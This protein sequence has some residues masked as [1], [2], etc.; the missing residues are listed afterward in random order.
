MSFDSEKNFSFLI[1]ATSEY[2]KQYFLE[3]DKKFELDVLDDEHKSGKNGQ[4]IR[5]FKEDVLKNLVIKYK[6]DSTLIQRLFEL[7]EN[8][9]LEIKSRNVD[10]I[11][12][13]DTLKY[14]KTETEPFNDQFNVSYILACLNHNFINILEVKESIFSKLLANDLN[15]N[16]LRDEFNQSLSQLIGSD[17]QDLRDIKKSVLSIFEQSLKSINYEFVENKIKSILLNPVAYLR[18]HFEKLKYHFYSFLFLN[19]RNALSTNIALLNKYKVECLNSITRVNELFRIELYQYC[20]NL[21]S[22]FSP[23]DLRAIN[24]CFL[25]IK[26][27]LFLNK[28]IVINDDFNIEAIKL[29]ELNYKI[30]FF[31]SFVRVI[32]Y[33]KLDSLMEKRLG[34]NIIRFCTQTKLSTSDDDCEN[35]LYLEN[36]PHDRVIIKFINLCSDMYIE[37]HLSLFEKI[38]EDEINSAG[39]KFVHVKLASAVAS[40]D[41]IFIQNDFDNLVF[42]LN[43]KLRRLVFTAKDDANKHHEY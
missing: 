33:S 24:A 43:K 14:Y 17:S 30:P 3:R 37:D 12:F 18:G 15:F 27:H 31:D 32:D 16:C 23:K 26:N 42:L 4:L 2:K 35:Y 25:L 28:L 6:N 22:S 29:C 38:N 20:L 34:L 1:E 13:F 41:E 7:A 10:S 19:N 8:E 40:Q 36:T 9:L 39:F 11:E 21:N 5:K